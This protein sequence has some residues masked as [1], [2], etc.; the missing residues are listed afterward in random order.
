MYLPVS[1]SERI[2]TSHICCCISSIIHVDVMG[3]LEVQEALSPLTLRPMVKCGTTLDKKQREKNDYDRSPSE[4]G[5]A[6][7]TLWFIVM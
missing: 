7:C 4:L 3:T 1:G 5:D 2:G 6:S